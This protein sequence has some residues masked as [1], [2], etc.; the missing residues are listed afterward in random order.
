M[1]I[2]KP[3][4]VQNKAL[5]QVYSHSES[6]DARGGESHVEVFQNGKEFV[7]D[8]YCMLNKTAA[9][10]PWRQILISILH[11][12]YK[13]IITVRVHYNRKESLLGF[14]FI[15]WGFFPSPFSYLLSLGFIFV[16]A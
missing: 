2:P 7:A 9:T 10:S 3:P 13:V 15:L 8:R 6:Y 14:L 4:G 1:K 16:F 12:N 5:T 11:T